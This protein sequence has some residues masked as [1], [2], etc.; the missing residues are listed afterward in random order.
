MYT[1]Y[2][3]SSLVGQSTSRYSSGPRPE[4]YLVWGIQHGPKLA[5]KRGNL[6][7]VGV[8]RF[9]SDSFDSMI[10]SIIRFDH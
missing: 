7:A 8:I 5:R 3:A 1:Y 2:V 9:D 10:D 6:R 4:R